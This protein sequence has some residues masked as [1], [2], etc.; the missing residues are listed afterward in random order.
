[1]LVTCVLVLIWPGWSPAVASGV[2]NFCNGGGGGWSVAKNTGGLIGLKRAKIN[3]HSN[4]ICL[5]EIPHDPG[6]DLTLQSPR[7]QK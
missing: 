5:L 7:G 3:V 6:R 2:A 1:M 4:M